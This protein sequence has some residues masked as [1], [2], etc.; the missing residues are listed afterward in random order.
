MGALFLLRLGQQ[1]SLIH[2][3]T[4]T[5]EN[6]EIAVLDPLPSLWALLGNP[7]QGFPYMGESEEEKKQC[8]MLRDN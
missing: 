1:L 2:I 6:T 3:F 7:F 4:A 8:D 5:E